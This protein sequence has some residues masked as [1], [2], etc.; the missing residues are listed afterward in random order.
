MCPRMG[1]SVFIFQ[2]VFWASEGIGLC[3]LQNLRK[4]QP[5]FFKYFCC[6]TLFLSFWD[7][8]DIHECLTFR[9]CPVDPWGY[10]H[11]LPFL[12]IVQIWSFLLTCLPVHCLFPLSFLYCY[13]AHPVGVSNLVLIFFSFVID[14]WFFIFWLVGLL[15]LSIVSRVF[16]FACWG[17]FITAAL[18]S[19]SVNSSNCVIS[20]LAFADCPFLLHL[21]IFW[22]FLCC[23]VLDWILEV[24]I[25]MRFW[26]LL[27]RKFIISSVTLAFSLFLDLYPDLFLFFFFSLPYFVLF[28]LF[29]WLPGDYSNLFSN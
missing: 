4:F 19:L 26:F 8:D 12:L 2:G 1:F 7:S 13:W 29:L 27:K 11:P 9:H 3:F 10:G 21:E 15:K 18:Q 28:N 23:L 6:P 24:L 16:T 22:C 14:I 5:Y 20:A 17:I 25:I